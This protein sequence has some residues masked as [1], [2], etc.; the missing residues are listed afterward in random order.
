[1]PEKNGFADH[2]TVAP[3]AIILGLNE[4]HTIFEIPCYRILD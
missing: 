4:N 3:P 1:M 2:K